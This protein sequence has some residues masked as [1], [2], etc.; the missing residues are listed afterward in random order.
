MK[1]IAPKK[2]AISLYE[3]LKSADAVKHPA[4]INSFIKLLARHKMLSKAEK[5]V[6]YF[7]LYADEKENIKTVKISLAQPLEQNIKREVIGYLEKMLSYKVEIQEQLQP[8][9]IGG[10]MIE[11]DDVRIDGSIKKQLELLSQNFNL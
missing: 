10:I 7:K 6:E 11:Y 4:L 1:H 8:D 9:L 2:Y 5:I 3:V